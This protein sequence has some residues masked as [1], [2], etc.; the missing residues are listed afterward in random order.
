MT[1]LKTKL[2]IKMSR[3]IN[4]SIITI[5]L[6]AALL[7]A[8]SQP[9]KKPMLEG[10]IN[11]SEPTE[12]TFV[13]D[14][15]GD[16]YS[17]DV[18]TDS[19]GAFVFDQELNIPRT[20]MAIYAGHTVYGAFVEQGK[21]TSMNIDDEN[22]TFDGDNV[23]INNFVNAYEQAYSPW[24]YKPTPDKPFV[25][26]EYTE[27]LENGY[28][29]A[30]QQLA[31]ISD[32][33]IR[34]NYAKMNEAR[35]KALYLQNLNFNRS[36]NKVD[37]SA[38]FDSI[39]A[40][41]DPNAD[42]TRTSGLIN[43]WYSAAQ[44]PQYVKAG[45]ALGFFTEIY[46]VIDSV[47]TNESNKKSLY[48]TIGNMFFMYQ[49][50]DS[51][52]AAF[53]KSVEP[54]LTNAPTITEKFNNIMAERAKVIKDGS[55]LPSNPILIAPDGSKTTLNDELQGKVVYIDIWAT[56]CGPCCREIPFMEK[57]AE[58]YKGND[59]IRF[60]SISEDDDRDAWLEKLDRDKP[61][62]PQFIFDSKTGSEFRKE[63]SINSIPRFLLIGSDG[64][65]IAVNAPR[66]SSEEISKLI[67]SA[68]AGE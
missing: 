43:Y 27:R 1:K 23:E 60:I 45:D 24:K 35:H 67:D 47:L 26:E 37:V 48:L 51:T 12:I 3:I 16:V 55:Q 18:T 32:N 49:F 10:R 20:N 38:E 40:T 22:V 65:L 17:Y 7:C 6:S 13:Y 56:W 52:N 61:E 58:K 28:N 34:E 39:V 30:K 21:S 62:W 9:E 33:D 31:T 64:R 8:C 14:I 53:M 59:K 36:F 15:D 66:P 25:Y 42:E 50:D 5:S 11:V 57:L 29:N 41:I 54:Y 2:Y 68:I 19:T 63:M 46:G 44:L 4:R